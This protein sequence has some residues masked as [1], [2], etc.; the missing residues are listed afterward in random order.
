[1]KIIKIIYYKFFLSFLILI[2]I[3]LLLITQPDVGQTL[4]TFLTWLSLIFVSGINL[5]IFFCI[6]YFT[7]FFVA[8]SNIYLFQINLDIFLTDYSLFLIQLQEIIINQ[9]KLQRQL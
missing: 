6:F 9:K 1:M 3:T 4:L 7:L 5:I 8:R 2:P